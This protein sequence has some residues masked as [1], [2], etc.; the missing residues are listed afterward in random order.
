M[1]LLLRHPGLTQAGE[2]GRFEQVA[3]L[4]HAPISWAPEGS[5]G[6]EARNARKTTVGGRPPAGFGKLGAGAFGLP[7]ESVGL[8]KPSVWR[9][10]PLG[11]A[12]RLFEPSDRLVGMCQQ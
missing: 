6:F 3:N 7:F 1:V 10:Q 9:D 5:G 11:G 12:C 4:R 8:S 2:I